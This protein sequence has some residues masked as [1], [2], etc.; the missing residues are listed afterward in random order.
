MKLALP[1]FQ[2]Y[3]VLIRYNCRSKFRISY[4]QHLISFARSF[5]LG[6]TPL[7]RILFF[8]VNTD[9]N[10]SCPWRAGAALFAFFPTSGS[11]FFFF[12]LTLSASYWNWYYFS[13]VFYFFVSVSHQQKFQLPL[14][15]F[16]KYSVIHF[17]WKYIL[18]T[19]PLT[20]VCFFLPLFR[21][22]FFLAM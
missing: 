1:C 3:D 4:M 19:A 15:T 12:F 21:R 13:I 17:L 11:I 7:T 20:L 22:R 6:K 10:A 16:I 5:S 18:K 9:K 2:V 14:L 8:F